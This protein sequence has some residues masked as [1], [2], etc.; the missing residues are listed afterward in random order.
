MKILIAYAGRVGVT[1][2]CAEILKKELE[3]RDVTLC[4]LSKAKPKLGEYDTVVIG[5]AIYYG[6][7]EKSVKS[8]I[9][10]KATEL[11]NKNFRIL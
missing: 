4:D 2:E 1:E 6:K 5:S 3:G 11:E 8:F 7:A 9:K 10:E